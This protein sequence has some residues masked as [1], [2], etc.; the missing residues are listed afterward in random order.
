MQVFHPQITAQFLDGVSSSLSPLKCVFHFALTSILCWSS[1]ACSI[2]V[3]LFHIHILIIHYLP[4]AKNKKNIDTWNSTVFKWV[5]ILHEM[6][7]L[8]QFT[9]VLQTVQNIQLYI[10]IQVLQC[11]YNITQI[12]RAVVNRYNMSGPGN[13]PFTARLVSEFMQVGLF[14]KFSNTQT[15]AL[16]CLPRVDNCGIGMNNWLQHTFFWNN[17]PW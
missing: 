2:A 13:G 6:H 14:F 8:S 1:E 3:A 10:V 9:T 11:T 15:M 4:Y 12:Q 17:N 7:L 16:G 5:L